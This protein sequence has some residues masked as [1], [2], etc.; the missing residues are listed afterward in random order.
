MRFLL[1][2]LAAATL[3]AAAPAAAQTASFDFEEFADT[4]FDG[5]LT[6]LTSSDGGLTITITRPGSS[7]DVNTG[8]TLGLPD[9]G[10]PT[11]GTNSLSPFVNGDDANPAPFVVDFSSAVDSFSL[12]FGDYGADTDDLVTLS[13]FAGAGG[14]GALLGTATFLYGDSAFPVIGSLALA[15]TGPALSAVFAGGGA[16]FPNSLYYDNFVATGAFSG[17]I[18]EPATWAML[19]GGIGFTGGALRTRRRT[20]FA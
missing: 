15:G 17:A 8:A 9:F 2:A 10:A 3:L 14:T 5:A 19:I 4:G 20:A 1:P 13:L 7:F 11:F 16:D 12:E 6:S 18:P